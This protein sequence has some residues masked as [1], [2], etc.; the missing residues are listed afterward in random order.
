LLVLPGLLLPALLKW[1]RPDYNLPTQFL[2]F[3]TEHPP[4]M[5]IMDLAVEV[6]VVVE[7]EKAEATVSH[8]THPTKG[9]TTPIMQTGVT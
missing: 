6:G 7:E 9:I 4:T 5:A 3:Q 2:E 1:S 8:P